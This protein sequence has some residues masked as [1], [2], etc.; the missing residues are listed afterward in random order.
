MKQPLRTAATARRKL[1]HLLPWIVAVAGLVGCYIPDSPGDQRAYRRYPAYAMTPAAATAPTAIPARLHW[2]AQHCST[3]LWVGDRYVAEGTPNPAQT[4]QCGLWIERFSRESIL[5]H[6]ADCGPYPGRAVLRGRLSPDGNA[7]LDGVITWTYHPCCGL[8]A[9]RFVAAWGAA[10]DSVP[11]NDAELA[12]YMQG[13]APAPAPRDA[14]M[15]GSAPASQDSGD[16]RNERIA[17]AVVKIVAAVVANAVAN[18]PSVDAMVRQLFRE[19]RNGVIAS[20]LRDAFPALSQRQAKDITF[21]IA[22]ELDGT[23]NAQK[24]TVH[25]TKQYV[26]DQLRAIDPTLADAAEIAELVYRVHRAVAAQ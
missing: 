14:A 25:F 3:W 22:S 17:E 6:R 21:F 23:L 18:D 13:S 12:R 2:C 20:T 5:M 11:G 4:P 19:I 8:G 1:N 10:I 26:I 24:V 9:G 7:I 15:Q 16:T